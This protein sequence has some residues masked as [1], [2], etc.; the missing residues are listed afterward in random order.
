M[1]SRKNPM[2][3]KQA[4]AEYNGVETSEVLRKRVGIFLED[5]IAKKRQSVSAK[6]SETRL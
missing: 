2:C 4:A 1:A 5:D 6:L 3:N